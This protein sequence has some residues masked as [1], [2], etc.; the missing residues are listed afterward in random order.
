MVK[1]RR[2]DPVHNKM[3]VL[4]ETCFPVQEAY[5]KLKTRPD[6]EKLLRWAKDGLKA[7]NGEHVFLDTCRDGGKVCTSIEAYF[8]FMSALVG[9]KEP[10]EAREEE[11]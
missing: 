11:S 9:G 6:A 3:Q 1:G 8:R 4:N 5:L 10:E 7:A 2:F